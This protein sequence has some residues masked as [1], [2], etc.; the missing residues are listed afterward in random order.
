M[1]GIR[2]AVTRGHMTKNRDLKRRV[3]ER[4]A[5]TGESYV[6]ARR[7]VVAAR[8]EPDPEPEGVDVVELNEVTERARRFGFAC[9]IW[10]YPRLAARVDETALLERL[11]EVML[12]TADDAEMKH[13]VRLAIAGVTPTMRPRVRSFVGMRDFYRRARAGLSGVSPSGEALSLAVAGKAGLVPVMCWSTHVG[14]T[15]FAADEHE[16]PFGVVLHIRTLYLEIEGRRYVVEDGLV[17]G[18]SPGKCDVAIRDGRVSRRHAI[19]VRVG[20]RFFL[21][22]LSQNGITYKGMK[23]SNKRIE[24]GDVFDLAGHELRFV[25]DAE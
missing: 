23:I 5:Q 12:A 4:Q 11:R 9:R 2:L 15:L 6:T 17:I 13:L 3:R 22:D 24:H 16:D 10:I 25:Y 19:I 20:D 7:Q 21:K 8:T 18:R 14:L 1:H